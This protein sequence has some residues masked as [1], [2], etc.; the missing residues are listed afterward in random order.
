MDP[1]PCFISLIDHNNKPLLIHVVQNETCKIDAV[2]KYNTF[3]NM[4]LDYF[5]SDLYEWTSANQNN[6]DIKDLFHL[7]GVTVYGKLVRQT[8]LKIVIGFSVLVSCNDEEI[9]QVFNE[10]SRLF[11]K[12]KVNPF[13]NNETELMEQLQARFEEKYADNVKTQ[14]PQ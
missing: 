12:C 7:E 5:E 8:R 2:L 11:I 1:Q 13:V 4:A 10:V 14:K 6:K 9:A 3:S